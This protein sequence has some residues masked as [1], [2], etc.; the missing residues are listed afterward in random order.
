MF[1]CAIHDK[2]PFICFRWS[3]IAS[4]LKLPHFDTTGMKKQMKARSSL[5]KKK[6]QRAK[7]KRLREKGIA[8]P[9]NN[10]VAEEIPVK[11]D[12]LK[13]R[14]AALSEDKYIIISF[15]KK[16]PVKTDS[17]FVRYNYDEDD[18]LDYDKQIIKSYLDSNKA[19]NITLIKVREH[20]GDRKEDQLEN[21]HTSI[22]KEHVAIF[23]MKLG[24]PREKIKLTNHK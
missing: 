19:D 12:S 17:I 2:F 10:S 18:V 5:R 23:F 16:A 15:D 3:C 8:V 14:F 1:S 9:D 6:R 24:I 21:K 20:F 11:K 22:T 13:Y 4:E 7:N